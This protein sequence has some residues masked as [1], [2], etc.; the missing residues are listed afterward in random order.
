MVVTIEIPITPV[1]DAVWPTI[2]ICILVGIM[3]GAV[4][5]IIRATKYIRAILRN[6]NGHDTD[7]NVAEIM[8]YVLIVLCCGF[9]IAVTL[10]E[11]GVIAF[12]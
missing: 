1:V 12:V 6:K 9:I 3:I 7:D 2:R 5:Y 8:G 10:Y 4:Y 11:L